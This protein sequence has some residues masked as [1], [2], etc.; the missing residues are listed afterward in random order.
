VTL[1]SKVLRA[2]ARDSVIGLKVADSIRDLIIKGAELG[3]LESYQYL[4][5]G[6]QLVTGKRIPA[7]WLDR[8]DRAIETDAID[9]LSVD[10]IVE[11]M[12]QGPR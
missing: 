12:L 5:D 7:R 9:H 3:E 11:I 2:L 4:G 8:L 6:G 10:R 1:P